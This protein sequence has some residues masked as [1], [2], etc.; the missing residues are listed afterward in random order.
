MM[1]NRKL[2]YMLV[3]VFLVISAVAITGII[4][5]GAIG[6]D[7]NLNIER[8][9]DKVRNNTLTVTGTGKISV[10]PDVAY[11][12]LGVRTLDKDAK[13]AQDENKAIMNT[14]MTKLSS[15]NIEE[16][17]IKHRLIAFGQDITIVITGEFGGL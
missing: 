13:K 12:E 16:K 6:S 7:A 11:L 1:D 4:A 9:G 10:K 3:G 5:A 14:I 8:A 2:I 15:L 17:D